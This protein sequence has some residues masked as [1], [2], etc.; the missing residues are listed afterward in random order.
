MIY[1]DF[2]V[3]KIAGWKRSFRSLKL[4]Y[5]HS[6]YEVKVHFSRVKQKHLSC[7]IKYSEICLERP[8]LWET[9][10]L[11]RPHFEVVSKDRFHCIREST[12][13]CGY[14]FPPDGATNPPGGAT[15]PPGADGQGAAPPG[16]EGQGAAPPGGGYSAGSPGADGY[17]VSEKRMQTKGKLEISLLNQF[18]EPYCALFN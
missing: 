4:L 12:N 9:T 10:C 18:I 1:N 14:E 3:T 15:N 2:T 5:I 6:V 17:G 16:A 13:H 7:K 11:Q 8:L